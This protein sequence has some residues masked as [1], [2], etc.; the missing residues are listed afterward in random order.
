V[1]GRWGGGHESL[2]SDPR[3]TSPAIT[4]S[5][6]ERKVRRFTPLMNHEG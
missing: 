4:V 1:A 6:E 5:A 3:I 2:V